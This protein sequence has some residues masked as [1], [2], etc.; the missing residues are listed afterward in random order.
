M[1]S[2]D[3]TTMWMTREETVT[4]EVDGEKIERRTSLGISVK[5]DGTKRSEQ[6]Y[7]LV[8]TALNDLFITESERFL[9]RDKMK[10]RLDEVHK[11]K[12]KVKS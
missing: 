7:D 4:L 5:S 10:D 11:R 8:D 12:P 9:D 1:G 3:L 2:V 6:L